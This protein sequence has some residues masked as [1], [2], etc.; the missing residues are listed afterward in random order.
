MTNYLIGL[1]SGLTMTKAVV[2]RDDGSVVAAGHCAVPQIKDVPRRVERDMAGHWNASVQAIHAALAAAANTE[3]H[4]IVPSGLGVAGHGDGIY[5]IDG[6]GAP[7]GLAATSLDSRAQNVVAGW[8][9]D[10]TSV[11]AQALCGQQ[12]FP[13][14]P[15]AL[16]AHMRDTDPARFARIGAVLSCKDWLRFCLTDTIGTDFTEASFSFTDVQTQTYSDAALDL[17]GLG[18][19]RHALP[20]VFLPAE[21]AG[22][23]TANAAQATGLP[24]GLPVAAGLHD[25]TACAVGSGISRPGTLAV[26]SGTYSINEMLR[27]SP[28]TAPGWL[29]RNGLMPG[30]WNCMAISPASSANLDWFLQH[31]AR[32]ALATGDPFT[33]LQPELDA[34][35]SDPSEIIYLPYLFGSPYRADVP[36]AFVGLRGWHDRGHMLR[37]VGEGIA[38]NHR[39]HV[40]T[41]DPD[42][43]IAAIR[44]TGGSSR[45]P[46]FAQLMADVLSRRVEVPHTQEAG[47]L[48]AAICAGIAAG[49]YAGWD[50]AMHKTAGPVRAYD[51]SPASRSLA[52]TY[53]RYK[54]VSATLAALQ[55]RITT[56]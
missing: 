50:D 39:H 43:E 37:A 41:L 22:H 4:P 20:P 36:G 53:E 29:T 52:T 31:A 1:D 17:F 11:R 8:D 6:D 7:L 51:P 35:A 48:G 19:L 42:R 21:V 56:P 38:F 9:A 15:A 3:G 25:V 5:L 18:D 23:I 46:Y 13:A 30:Q 24:Q 32:D 12:P 28:D 45:N 27:T 10:G 16:L 33:L 55:A 47:A 14:S 26:I 44:L 40:D 49:I 34:V 2:F 54:D